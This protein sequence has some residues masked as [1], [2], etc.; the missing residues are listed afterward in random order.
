LKGKKTAD[1][2]YTGQWMDDGV[3]WVAGHLIFIIRT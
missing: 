3:A 2:K 1:N